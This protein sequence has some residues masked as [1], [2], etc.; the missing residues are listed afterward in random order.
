MS[1]QGVYLKGLNGL[2]SIAALSVVVSHTF[3]AFNY[4]SFKKMEG[5]DFASYGVTMFFV[6]S[7]FLITFLLIKEKERF[8][9]INIKQFYIRRILR[10]WP[11]YYFFLAIAII[12]LK[13]YYPQQLSNIWYYVFM[14]ANIPYTLGIVLPFIVHYWSLG[15]EEQF[16][17]FWPWLI[18]KFSPAWAVGIFLL[19]FMFLKLILLQFVL[20][21]F[22]HK[23]INIT[24]F[25]CMAI[26]ALF[27]ILYLDN[28]KLVIQ[29][30]FNLGVQILCWLVWVLALVGKLNVPLSQDIF[31]L[32][33]AVIILNV[34]F[35]YKTI[36]N[37]ENKIF[38]FFGKIS[39]GIYVYHVLVLYFLNKMMKERIEHYNNILQLIIV[40]TI[41]L[42]LTVLISWLSYNYIEKRFIQL[43]AKFSKILSHS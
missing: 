16:Y 29:I 18:K 7:G 19:F 20:N 30:S 9:D 23:F 27:A 22:A 21:S 17:L 43:K 8:K 3:M 11:L 24:R 34:A 28:K 15:V 13:I 42:S 32:A 10:I 26:G 6:L 2:R 37:L 39:Y 41:V 14:G 1:E 5:W 12:L 40:I 36:V 25:D 31:S 4:F 35:N 38:N 33:S